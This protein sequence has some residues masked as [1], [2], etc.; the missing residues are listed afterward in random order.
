MKCTAF[1]RFAKKAVESEEGWEEVRI[2]KVVLVNENKAT[3]VRRHY[4]RVNGKR[5]YVRPL[6]GTNQTRREGRNEAAKIQ[7]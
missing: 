1:E 4:R 6:A 5:V 2:K 3:F 7:I